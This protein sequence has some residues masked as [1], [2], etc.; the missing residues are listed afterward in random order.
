MVDDPKAYRFC[1]YG[2]AVAGNKA[3][4]QGM[5]C[6]FDI[7]GNEGSWSTGA[8][9][10]SKQLFMRAAA[11]KGH[12]IDSKKIREVLDAVG[13]LSK[14]ELLHCKVRYLSDG[15]VLGSKTFVEDIFQKHRSEF[16]LKRKTGA[17]KPRYGEWG[18]LWTMRDLRLKPVSLSD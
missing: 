17:R 13:R 14:A 8:R 9:A 11:G 10:Y 2:E 1:G 5:K 4:K 18:A 6:I 7:L 3:A 12:V 15:V 16:G